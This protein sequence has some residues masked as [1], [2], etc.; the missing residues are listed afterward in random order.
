MNRLDVGICLS[1]MYIDRL[2]FEGAAF[3]F[4]PVVCQYLVIN[5]TQESA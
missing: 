2:I 3:Y 4:I 5:Y 1:C